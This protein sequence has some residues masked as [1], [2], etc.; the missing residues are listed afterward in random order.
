MYPAGIFTYGKAYSNSKFCPANVG[1][2]L[3]NFLNKS[4]NSFLIN[5]NPA[6]FNFS[7]FVDK[8]LAASSFSEGLNS[9][10]KEPPKSIFPD[11]S[12]LSAN[13]EL[14]LS[15]TSPGVLNFELD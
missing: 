12:A 13:N 4:A 8:F 9:F 10:P 11:L 1:F 5:S 15:L 2:S 7:V 6:D 14:I 3:S